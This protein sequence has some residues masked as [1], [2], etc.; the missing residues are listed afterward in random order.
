MAISLGIREL[1]MVY[2][3]TI[4][5]D[6]CVG[7][8]WKQGANMVIG[9]LLHTYAHQMSLAWQV[10]KNSCYHS[11]NVELRLLSLVEC[12]IW[13]GFSFV[14]VSVLNDSRYQ[15]IRNLSPALWYMQSKSN[16]C[17]VILSCTGKSTTSTIT[18]G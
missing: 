15:I 10:T 16:C 17:P 13:Q 12:N 3:S 2:T 4:R 11:F 6:L 18:L 9:T 14:V 5:I 1:L 8:L 7:S